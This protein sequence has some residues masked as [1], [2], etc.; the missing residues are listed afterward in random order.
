MSSDQPC[1]VD[2]VV[3]LYFLLAEQD[4]LLRELVGAPVAVPLTVYDPEEQTLPDGALR[5]SELLSEMRQSIRHYE[6]LADPETSG[7]G[8]VERVRRVDALHEQGLLETIAMDADERSLSAHLQSRDGAADHGL[9][10]P[11][12][13]GEA[14]CVAIASTRGWTI[15]TDDTAALTVMEIRHGADGFEYERIR[16]LLIRA[17]HQGLITEAGA[18]AIHAEMRQLGF[19]DTGQPF[20]P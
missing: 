5:R 14:A 19:W 11:L 7:P 8:M 3:L 1:I 16:R 17:A 13:P 10:L 6:A 2:T 15:V 9:P 20:P 4:A 12:G 18:N